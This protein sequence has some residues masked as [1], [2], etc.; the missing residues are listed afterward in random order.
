MKKLSI[1]KKLMNLV[2]IYDWTKKFE[3]SRASKG[4][5]KLLKQQDLLDK[6][7]EDYYDKHFR[8]KFSKK[9]RK[10]YKFRRKE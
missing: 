5:D 4:L 7:I 9:N 6:K 8:I 1:D 2:G 3:N 10:K